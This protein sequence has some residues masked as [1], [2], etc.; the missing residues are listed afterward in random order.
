MVHAD[1][2]CAFKLTGIDTHD[3]A[4]YGL[5]HVRACVDRYNKDTDRP[6]AGEIDIKE[7]RKTVEDKDG[8][9]DHGRTA[10]KFNVCAD[11]NTDNPKEYPFDH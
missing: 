1:G 9:Q 2:F 6:Y 10:E 11:D 4:A 5:C 7:I 3:S 8:L